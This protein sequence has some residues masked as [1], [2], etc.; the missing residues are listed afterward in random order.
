MGRTVQSADEGGREMTARSGDPHAIEEEL[1]SSAGY[2]AAPRGDEREG[3]EPATFEDGQP[4]DPALLEEQ[5]EKGRFQP[6][7]PDAIDPSVA[8][9]T[10]SGPDERS[11]EPGAVPPGETM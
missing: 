7:E 11:D 9:V 5:R 4:I 1:E 3:E 6:K 8:R 2:Q 10:V